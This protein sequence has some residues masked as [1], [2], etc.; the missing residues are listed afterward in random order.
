VRLLEWVGAGLW[1][2]DDGAV[3]G[4]PENGDVGMPPQRALLPVHVEPVGECRVWLDR[5]L[6]Y[7]SSAMPVLFVTGKLKMFGTLGGSSSIYGGEGKDL[8][9]QDYDNT[10]M[11]VRTSELS[12]QR[13]TR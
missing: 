10:R 5:A 12:F 13:V 3:Q 2:D 9:S 7:H 4:C 11:R 6:C 1:A 8:A